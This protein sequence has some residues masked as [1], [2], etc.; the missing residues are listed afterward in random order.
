M[1]TETIAPSPAQ[2]E[3]EK[4]RERRGEDVAYTI[5]HSIVCTLTDFIDP[6]IGNHIQKHLGNDSQLKDSV[7]AEVAGDIGAVPVTIAVQRLFPGVMDGLSRMAE[8]LVGGLFHASTMRAAKAW[9]R[10]HHKHEESE[11]CTLRAEKIYRYE[12]R[13]LPQAMVWTVSSIGINVTAQCLLGNRA[14]LVH[15][16]AGKV[17][18]ATLTAFLT[19]GGRGLFP[20]QAERW[21]RWVSEHVLV[22]TSVFIGTLTGSNTNDE[23]K[24][25]RNKVCHEIHW[26]GRV[27][28]PQHPLTTDHETRGRRIGGWVA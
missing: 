15:I 6:Y 5:N 11:E 1:R 27:D 24:R 9:S 26:Q 12:M 20:H 21:D 13:H 7:I 18:G 28:T 23:P 3:R 25:P 8:P 16:L 22:P 4:T 2:I 10:A 14:P 17:G 19:T